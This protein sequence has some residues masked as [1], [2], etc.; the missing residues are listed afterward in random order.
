VIEST[1]NPQALAD[2]PTEHAG[3]LRVGGTVRIRSTQTAMPLEGR[4]AEIVPL[5]NPA[6]H[7][8]QFK[9]DLPSSFALPNGQFVKVEVPAG[10]RNALL[11]PGRSVRETGQ[12]TGLFVVDGAS[13]ARFRLVK[14]APYDAD[15][16]EV[17]SGIESGET[18]ITDLSSEVVDGTP[19]AARK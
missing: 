4:V 5:S 16:S 18:V 8:V 10:T 1:V 9:V 14:I 2:I 3:L 6:T 17:L 19:V 12:L 13:K 11:I 7:S 15:R